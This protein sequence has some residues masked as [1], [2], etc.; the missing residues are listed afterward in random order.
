MKYSQLMKCVLCCVCCT[1]WCLDNRGRGL[2]LEAFWL[3]ARHF[4]YHN[5]WQCSVQSQPAS[6]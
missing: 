6:S 2:P 1:F 3:D 5:G 4:H